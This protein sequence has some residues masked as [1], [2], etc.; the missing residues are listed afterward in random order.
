MAA[1]PAD[2]QELLRFPVMDFS[3]FQR[4][5]AEIYGRINSRPNHELQGW[6]E[7]GLTCQEW[8]IDPAHPWAAV[9]KYHGLAPA[10]RAAVDALIATD[11]DNYSN[12]RDLTPAEVYARHRAEL[13]KLP[14]YLIPRILGEELAKEITVRQ[15]L[16]TFEDRE[17]G[18]GENRYLAVARD[19]DGHDTLLREGQT[20]QVFVTPFWP[21]GAFICDGRGAYLGAAKRWTAPSRADGDAL[22][23]QYARVKEMQSAV[24]SPLSVYGRDQLRRR[25]ADAVHN[26]GVMSQFVARPSMRKASRGRKAAPRAA[27]ATDAADAALNASLLQ[28]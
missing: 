10:A 9:E 5:A 18:P 16:F 24:L 25:A 11:P 19:E 12:I 23:E 8:R 7:A 4:V 6:R 20:Y 2:T 15:K 28:Q 22:R 14:N 3:I 1:L 21:E 26:T 27:S 13:V 17:F